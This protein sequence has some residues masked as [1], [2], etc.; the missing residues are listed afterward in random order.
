VQDAQVQ[1]GP[2]FRTVPTS[3]QNRTAATPAAAGQKTSLFASLFGAKKK[4]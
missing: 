4:A 2:V 1:A 3:N